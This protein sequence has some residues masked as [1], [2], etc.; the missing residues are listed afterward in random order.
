M[1]QVYAES[2]T[3]G[4]HQRPEFDTMPRYFPF[5]PWNSIIFNSSWWKQNHAFAEEDDGLN[6]I[7]VDRY[8]PITKEL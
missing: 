2:D 5:G 7:C 3:V 8:L 1:Y 4:P 6:F